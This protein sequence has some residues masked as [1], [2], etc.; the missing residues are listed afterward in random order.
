MGLVVDRA[1]YQRR[2]QQQHQD[3]HRGHP[4][5]AI[6]A[7]ERAVEDRHEVHQ[8]TGKA[9]HHVHPDPQEAAQ[10]HGQQAE[11]QQR[12]VERHRVS[13]VGQR[14]V[15]GAAQHDHQR[16]Q[17][18]L[19]AE[20]RLHS[21]PEHLQQHQDP[22]PD[23]NR[24]G[25]QGAELELGPERDRHERHEARNGGEVVGGFPVVLAQEREH[26]AVQAD[27]H[28]RHVGAEVVGDRPHQRKGWQR[29]HREHERHPQ[30]PWL[31]AEHLFGADE[32][33]RHRQ[34]GP[35]VV[36][37]V[38]E[39]RGQPQ[40][41]ADRHERQQHAGLTGQEAERRRP[42]MQPAR[43]HEPAHGER[44]MQHAEEHQLPHLES[45]TVVQGLHAHRQ[46]HGGAQQD[47]VDAGTGL[48]EPPPKLLVEARPA[49]LGRCHRQR[50]AVDEPGGGARE[51]DSGRRAQ[52][53]PRHGSDR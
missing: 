43:T 18:N 51:Q 15:G 7:G 40:V 17:A 2:A 30:L 28:E 50:T 8:H 53:G 37:Q 11:D 47:Q 4:G 6:H 42:A 31:P 45:A 21:R 46:R 44:H 27:D 22:E 52:V 36:L 20:V 32:Q 48:G 3:A 25:V 26:Q 19:V 49:V 41:L 34:A 23:G 12:Q 33:E 5:G 38:P 35:D 9:Q 10:A 39:V 16:D 13:W 24:V 1:G 29:Q 14:V